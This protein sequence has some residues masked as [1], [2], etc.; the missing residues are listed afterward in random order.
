VA[1]YH[2]IQL[3]SGPCCLDTVAFEQLIAQDDL[4]ALRA[5]VE[6]YRAT[7]SWNV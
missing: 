1:D 5:A 7:I 6:L 2:T 3:Q 4:A